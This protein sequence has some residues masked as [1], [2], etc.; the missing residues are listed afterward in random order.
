MPH[1]TAARM[2]SNFVIGLV[3]QNNKT[4][5]SA[6]RVPHLFRQF[7]EINEV[8]ITRRRSLFR[9]EQLFPGVLAD[10]L[11]HEVAHF[12]ATLFGHDQVIC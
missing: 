11:Q 7:I 10:R 5:Q 6:E 8:P 1:S 12:A 2:F 4:F 3:A 9:V